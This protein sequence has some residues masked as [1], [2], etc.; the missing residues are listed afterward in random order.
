MHYL[1]QLKLLKILILLKIIIKD[2]V[3][4]LMKEEHFQKEILIMAEM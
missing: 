4:V 3:Y 1:V 2:M